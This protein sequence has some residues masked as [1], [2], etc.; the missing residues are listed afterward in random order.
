MSKILLVVVANNTFDSLEQ[1]LKQG[2]PVY[3]E[4]ENR[5]I[6]VSP[7]YLRLVHEDE[8]PSPVRFRDALRTLLPVSYQTEFR[9]V[10]KLLTLGSL[11]REFPFR[12]K[13][14][15]LQRI[16]SYG[17]VVIEEASRVFDSDIFQF[18]N[19][20]CIVLVH[21]TP[22]GQELLCAEIHIIHRLIHEPNDWER[23]T[24]QNMCPF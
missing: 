5:W 10:I 18:F 7:V 19:S 22:L 23:T 9:E 1:R 8:T 14:E 21:T 6:N 16:H 11:Y 24:T 2:V 12:D 4:T 15:E 20:I 3:D 13:D 17:Y